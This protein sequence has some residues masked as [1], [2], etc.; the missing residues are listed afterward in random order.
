MWTNNL[1]VVIAAW[2]NASKRSCV[3]SARGDVLNAFN[4]RK[5]G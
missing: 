1:C 3:R 2:L 4:S 5:N